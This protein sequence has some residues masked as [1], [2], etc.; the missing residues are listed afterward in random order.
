MQ[1]PA[2]SLTA[3]CVAA[4]LTLLFSPSIQAQT[5]HGEITGEVTDQ[6]GAPAAKVTIT[7]TNRATGVRTELIS[8][9]VGRFYVRSMPPGIYDIE[10]SLTGFKTYRASG[11]ELSTGQVLRHD[12]RLEVGD[13]S[14]RV[15][16]VADAGAVEIQKDSADI[17]LTL[18]EVTIMQMPKVTRKTMELI[19]LNPATVMTSKG[20]LNDNYAGASIQ[21]SIG[22]NPNG[23]SNMYYL[24][25]ITTGRAR[26][27]GD[28]GNQSDINPNPEIMSELRVVSRFS[29]EFG[30]AIGGVIMMTTKSGTNQ[31]RGQVYYYGQN[32][33]LDATNFFAT[34]KNPNRIHNYGG[35]I[36]G[37]IIQNKTFFLVN[38]EHQY[39]SQF[40]PTIL[41]LPTLQQRAGDFSQTLTSSGGL[42]RIFDPATT[43]MEAGNPVRDPFPGNVIPSSRFD[44]IASNI[45]NNYVPPPNSAGL[46]TGGNN[47]VTRRQPNKS[48]RYWQFYRLD[49]NLGQKD[50]FYVRYVRDQGDSDVLGPYRGTPYAV[51]DPFEITQ[52]QYGSIIA[53]SWTRLMSA[54]RLSE[55]TFSYSNFPLNREALGTNPDVWQKDWAGKL[56]I[57]NVGPDTFP[58]FQVAGYGDIGSFTSWTQITHPTMRSMQFGET[59]SQQ[60]GKHNLRFGGSWK[61]SRAVYATRQA[62]SGSL[63]FDTR[64]T[65]LPNVASTGN[66]VASFLLGEVA[67]ARIHD[68][69]PGDYRSSL[70]TAFVQ[71]DWRVR[72]N[73]TLNIGVR[74]EY[75]TPKIN[76][77]ERNSL[78]NFNKT[79]PVCNCPGVIEFA[80]NRYQR[81]EDA[82]NHKHTPLYRQPPLQFAPRVGFAWTPL[83]RGDL[84]VRG[85]Y[86]IFFAGSDY[87]DVFWNGPLLGSG[88]VAD[89]TSDGLGLNAP[90]RLANSF[91]VTPVQPLDDSWGA[92][93]IGQLPRIDPTFFYYDRRAAYS[94]QYNLTVQKQFGG[95]LVEVGYLGNGVR[96]LAPPGGYLNYN[97]VVPQVRGPGNAQVRRPFP[98]FGNVLGSGENRY[99]SNYHAAFV[100]L[101]RSYTNGLT[102]QTNYTFAK[103]LD[104]QR[105]RSYYNLDADYGPAL[106]NLR[107]RFVWASN[108]DLPFGRGKRYGNSGAIA[109]LLGG[110]SLGAILDLRSGLPFSITSNTNTCN[111]F[112]T[113]NQG[114]DLAPG[115]NWRK[116]NDGFD[117]GKDTW[118]N[119]S[120]FQFAQPFTFGN[121]GKGIIQAPGFAVLDASL[122]KN[123][124]LTERFS[125]EVRAEF[126]NSLNRVNFNGPNTALG[127]AAF[128]R[129]TSAMDPRRIQL[130]SALHF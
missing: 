13:M 86:G 20:G 16:V 42:I 23:R 15:E 115:G 31:F 66:S 84:V 54:T 65:A 36:G 59:L 4:F 74:Y 100:S 90:F 30:E 37:P 110:W 25:G 53:G 35:V 127:N 61:S 106:L 77:T 72:R 2:R 43:R 112:T 28:G 128:G 26:M 14:T 129:I 96:K 101:K 58:N 85:G 1:V 19:T 97:E 118:F 122:L 121:V 94:M 57:R 10:A 91:P 119:T 12:F 51:A 40:Q 56:G 126:M 27:N 50:R 102:F 7:L 6:T 99:T 117:P 39:V 47:L 52:V 76:V 123:T 130:G 62:A 103:Q 78:F 11:I 8:N 113:G 33:A 107:H 32:D 64:A 67:T 49:H 3:Y 21:F 60:Y 24:D 79:N 83:S 89:Y 124:R 18:S 71:D 73:L 55:A 68:A 29:A 38:L 88:T 104:N 82:Y 34:S 45:L 46:I 44:P 69:P 109:T 95:H 93:P 17:S 87:G 48:N 120:A 108:Y 92:V 116:D 80:S 111:C 9:E 70:F 98:Q 22:G 41:T 105:P 125:L 5:A 63:R 114:V 81:V 75:D